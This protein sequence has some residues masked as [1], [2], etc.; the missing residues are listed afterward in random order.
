FGVFVAGKGTGPARVAWKGSGGKSGIF[1][2]NAAFVHA[3]VKN[4]LSG[5]SYA[6][7]L[8][9]KSNVPAN[10]GT[11]FA[12]AGTGPVFSPTRLTARLVE[13]GSAEPTLASTKQ[14]SLA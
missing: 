10:G 7:S 8:R 13:T 3:V 6:F 14:Y 4:L 11:I 1:S 2:P 9:W 12:G 5:H